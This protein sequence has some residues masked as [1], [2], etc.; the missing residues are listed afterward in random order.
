MTLRRLCLIGAL[1][2]PFLTGGA[3]LRAQGPSVESLF[4]DAAAKESAV[5]KALDVAAPASTVLKAVRTVVS[6]FENV[7]RRYPASGFSDDAL[8]RGGRR[9][10]FLRHPI[11]PKRDCE[12]RNLMGKRRRV[13]CR[14]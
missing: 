6:D 10:S 9:T 5:R 2:L 7:V 11:A 14:A 8:W 13:V 4:A 3:G 12:T 1:L